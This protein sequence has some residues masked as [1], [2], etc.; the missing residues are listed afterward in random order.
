MT[1]TELC[2]G[3]VYTVGKAGTRQEFLEAARRALEEAGYKEP[4]LIR[5][6]GRWGL[7]CAWW[8]VGVSSAGILAEHP[9]LV[10]RGEEL[11]HRDGTLIIHTY[12][13]GAWIGR[14]GRRVRA[15]A[16]KWQVPIMVATGDGQ[17]KVTL[18]RGDTSLKS[19]A[20]HGASQLDFMLT[21]G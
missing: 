5:S 9:E 13:P 10:E 14:E 20:P 16:A 7:W 12:R 17:G 19:S 18:P 1:L 15:L 6:C 2:P 11:S 4:V 8:A 3:V 21:R